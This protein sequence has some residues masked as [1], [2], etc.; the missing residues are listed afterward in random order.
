MPGI[1][2]SNFEYQGQFVGSQ[3]RYDK[4]F[5]PSAVMHLCVQS[6]SALYFFD[7]YTLSPDLH[8][9]S[10]TGH[11]LLMLLL[12]LSISI[13]PERGHNNA[14][15]HTT[16]PTWDFCYKGQSDIRDTSLLYLKCTAFAY[17]NIL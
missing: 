5:V 10:L 2:D 8:D 4:P 7:N 3:K 15:L 6:K 12:P 17:T 14:C 9:L 1:R 11:S 13:N 16:N